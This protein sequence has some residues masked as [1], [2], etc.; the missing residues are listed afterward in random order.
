MTT[1]N[2]NSDTEYIVVTDDAD[3][4]IEVVEVGTQGPT[5]ATGATGTTGP[6]GPT[7]PEGPPETFPKYTHVQA[8]PSSA[9]VIPHGI[10]RNPISVLVVD[11]GG[12]VINGEIVY[13][14]VNDITI[15]FDVAP[16]AGTAYLN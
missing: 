2:L 10:G 12:S 14:D 11:G 4:V 16:F 7:G 3:P 1:V 5:G 9:W 15:I 8:V 6:V 13:V